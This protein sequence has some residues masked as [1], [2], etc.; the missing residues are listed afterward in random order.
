MIWIL[1]RLASLFKSEPASSRFAS[2]DDP[3]ERLATA[4]RAA[5]AEAERLWALDVFDPKQSDD[6]PRAKHSKLIIT[7][8][9]RSA[10]WGWKAPYRGDGW[11]AWC[12]MF[13]AAC[14]KAA[15]ADPKWFASFWVSTVRLLAWVRYLPFLGKPNPKPKTGPYRLLAKITRKTKTLPFVPRA[16]DILVIGNGDP[17]AGDH[18]CLVVSYDAERRCFSTLEGNAGGIGP[19]GK[20]REGIVKAERYIDAPGYVAMWLYRLA[21]SDLVE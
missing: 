20:W 13:V 18:I 8:I 12:G 1:E 3:D 17:E 5:V 19:D 15:G 4:G 9:L 14:W 16:G 11:V 10:G 21:P 6:S 2:V 7:D